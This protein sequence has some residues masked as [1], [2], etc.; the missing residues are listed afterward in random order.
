MLY[1]YFYLCL[2]F[3]S[4]INVNGALDQEAV[5][6]SPV[7]SLM[8][9][10]N[11]HPDIISERRS[12]GSVLGEPVCVSNKLDMAADEIAELVSSYTYKFHVDDG[13]SALVQFRP[14]AI[15]HW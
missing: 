7:Q 12:A 14:V 1:I 2:C 4:K 10:K 9:S 15:S 5:S 6:V 8:I 11:A 3:R 13:N